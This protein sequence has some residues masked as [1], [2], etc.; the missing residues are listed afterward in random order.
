MDTAP[1]DKIVLCCSACG[2]EK[3]NDVDWP[4]AAEP[5]CPGAIW[6][7][8]IT[9]TETPEGQVVHGDVRY[10]ARLDGGVVDTGHTPGTDEGDQTPLV[11]DISLWKFFRATGVPPV[12]ASTPDV[13][14]AFDR[15]I[16]GAQNALRL[17]EVLQEIAAYADDF[18]G[19]EPLRC[20]RDMAM[21][22]VSGEVER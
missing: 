9:F 11:A 10:G 20:V 16:R 19:S 2:K 6:T 8:T 13:D 21:A 1:S 18:P 15:I 12:G 7:A 22:A 14:A 5:C 3:P 17:S 4:R